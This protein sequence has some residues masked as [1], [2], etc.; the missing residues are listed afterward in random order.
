MSKN[1]N[2]NSINIKYK[3]MGASR[4]VTG[5]CHLISIKVENKEFNIVIDY[6]IVQN[7]LKKLNELHNIN[8]KEKAVRW[9][10]IDTIILTHSHADH[11]AMLPVAVMNGFKG[12]I[13]MTAPTMKLTEL[14]LTD[15]A[16]IQNRE[17]ERYNKTKKGK[18][19]PIYP[20]Y[21]QR[22]VE[23][24]LDR[25]KGYDYNRKIKL[26][27]NIV[28]TLY[29]AGHLLGASSP[30]IEIKS[31]E[32]IKRIL[33]TGDTSGGKKLPF[34]KTPDFK[35]LKVD[36]LFS[37]GTYGDKIQ[38][39]NNIK[40]KLEKYIEQTILKD[41]GKVVI[42]VFSVGRSSSVVEYLHEIISENDRYEDVSV[43]L[44]SPMAC[45]SHR[46]YGDRDSFNFYNKEYEKSKNIFT[47]SGIQYIEEYPILKKEVL[48]N[49]PQIVLVSSGMVCGGYSNAVALGMLP[50]DNSVMLFCGY[51]GLGSTGRIILESKIGDEIEID[52]KIVERKCQIDFM[53]M[54]SH[55]DYKTIIKMIKDMRHTKIK[56]VFLN[57][58]DEEPLSYFKDVLQKELNAEIIISDYDKWYKLT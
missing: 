51:Q 2:V 31:G 29:S 4:Q 46:I 1:R 54:S 5:S 55:A 48:N 15:S 20:I 41:K 36:Y 34:T 40:E 23:N 7:N 37:E 22:H 53:N 10:K 3:C 6:G 33:F 28:L 38:G 47:W 8:K 43:I 58:G 18:K 42:P 11:S 49:K 52:N 25:F 14:I 21:G 9:D 56:K 39:K 44:A 16:F 17:T 12:D 30:Y 24:T 19:N 35:D 32:E 13:I 26:S 45:K 57:H 27:D 50:H